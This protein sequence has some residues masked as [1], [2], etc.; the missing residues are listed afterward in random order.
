M[1]GVFLSGIRK[2][3]IDKNAEQHEKEATHGQ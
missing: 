3:I 2:T 1:G